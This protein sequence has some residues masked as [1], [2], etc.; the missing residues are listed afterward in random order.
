MLNI[1]PRPTRIL[2]T[3]TRKSV[4]YVVYNNKF[5]HG[6]DGVTTTKKKVVQS[7]Y[8]LG[9]KISYRSMLHL[10]VLNCNQSYK[11]HEWILIDLELPSPGAGSRRLRSEMLVAFRFRI[12]GA[13][14]TAMN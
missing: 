1:S 3:V 7:S 11:T 4:N 9:I 8:V 14:E 6:S 10:L 13:D 12:Q 2:A 5:V